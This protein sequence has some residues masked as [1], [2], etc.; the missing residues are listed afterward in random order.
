[1]KNKKEFANIEELEKAF[2]AYTKNRFDLNKL[3]E[4]GY[5]VNLEQI[6]YDC[7]HLPTFCMMIITIQAP[8]ETAYTEYWVGSQKH[9]TMLADEWRRG[10]KD[11]LITRFDAVMKYGQF[12]ATAKRIINSQEIWIEKYNFKG[13]V[14]N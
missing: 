14:R 13:V 4:A 11:D 1:M 12:C 5:D 3:D 6:A 7:E 2:D 9:F 8:E 10:A